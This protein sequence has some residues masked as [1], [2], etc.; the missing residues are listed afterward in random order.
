MLLSVSRIAMLMALP[1]NP[2]NDNSLTMKA[3]GIKQLAKAKL[4]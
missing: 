2:H 1:K 3:L 4:F